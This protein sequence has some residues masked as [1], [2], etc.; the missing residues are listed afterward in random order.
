MSIALIENGVVKF[1]NTIKVGINGSIKNIGTGIN[2]VNGVNKLFI[3]NRIIS[4]LFVE[5]QLARSIYSPTSADGH[6]GYYTLT[7]NNVTNYGKITLYNDSI[8]TVANK[9]SYGINMFYRFYIQYT[10]GSTEYVK[11]ASKNHSISISIQST[12]T[13]NISSS[14]TGGSYTEVFGYVKYGSFNTTLSDMNEF[15]S[16]TIGFYTPYNIQTHDIVRGGSGSI[17]RTINFKSAVIDGKSFTPQLR[18]VPSGWRLP[19]AT[20]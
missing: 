17:T 1:T 18:K 10:D 6:K 12:V 7:P 16:T 15:S 5:L 13:S 8:Y 2:K 4:N 9:T 3:D 20:A 14:A 11:Q 19:P